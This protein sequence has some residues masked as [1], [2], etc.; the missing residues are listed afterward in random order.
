MERTFWIAVVVMLA[1]LVFRP[2]FADE[3]EGGGDAPSQ[4]EMMAKW[5]KVA[6][7][8]EAHQVLQRLA[9]TW[10][11]RFPSGPLSTS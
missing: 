7:P 11:T 3:H 10:T 2:G 6:T 4:E 1:L 8:G 5:L 9:G